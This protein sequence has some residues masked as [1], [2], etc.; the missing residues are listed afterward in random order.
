M[1]L[2]QELFESVDQLTCV[3]VGRSRLDSTEHRQGAQHRHEH[4]GRLHVQNLGRRQR[5]LGLRDRRRVARF[6]M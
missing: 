1:P 3:D 2:T 5:G 6:M 4:Q